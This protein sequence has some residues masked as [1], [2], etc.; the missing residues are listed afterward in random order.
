MTSAPALGL[1]ALVRELISEIIPQLNLLTR[2]QRVVITDD[3]QLNGFVRRVVTTLDDPVT[4]PLLRSGQLCFQLDTAGN[5][6]AAVS[7][8]TA[9]A[10]EGQATD[11]I[12]IDKGVLTERIVARAITE[13]ARL[14][15]GRTVVIT[16][17]AREQIRKSS[18]EVVR[19]P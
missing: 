17:L 9:P 10:A 3:E 14:V 8:P 7:S 4:G 16:P 5:G 6:A 18:V 11:S 19:R 2:P 12:E 15:L 1:R 13:R